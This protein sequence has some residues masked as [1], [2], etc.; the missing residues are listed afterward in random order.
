MP[1]RKLKLDALLE[2]TTAISDNV[3]EDDLYRI[4][5]F[6][7]VSNP[8]LHKI[9][10]FVEDGEEWICKFSN[11]K[12]LKKDAHYFSFEI[13]I[14]LENSEKPVKD[15]FKFLNSDVDLTTTLPIFHRDKLLA[16]I[17][18]S[19]KEEKEI[20]TDD[21]YPI[22]SFI[23]TL[24]RIV[25]TAIENKRMGR[26]RLKQEALNKELDIAKEVQE[27]LFPKK[28]TENNLYH[29]EAS[30]L[31][32]TIVG[33]D[34]YDYI[35]LSDDEFLVCIADV[36]GKGVPASILM[37]NFQAGL[38]VL[39]NH[40]LK[41]SEILSDLNKMVYSNANAERF[42]TAFVAICNT[43]TKKIR[44]INAG[45]TPPFLTNG[46]ITE[47]LSHGTT[48]IGAVD[49][50]PYINVTEVSYTKDSLLFMYTDG[51]VETTNS[52]DEEF[53]EERIKKILPTYKNM[54]L[55]GFHK[56]VL[57]ELKAFSENDQY[58]D[59]LTILSCKFH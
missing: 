22:K 15:V 52:S 55:K 48:L 56:F 23:R 39:S 8:Q 51:L 12:F 29:V 16:L 34:Y 54:P 45:H 50:L 6:T 2:I 53:G 40:T 27:M 7:M 37:S 33:G 36:S 13:N 9:A 3:S 30:Y 14:P 21:D 35:K 1:L 19:E 20:T 43:A 28:L 57:K 58:G 5:Y 26:L 31:P 11:S 49:E 59:D 10:L 17:L 24:G 46:K 18:I 32:H 4:F 41:L 44:Y 47:S 42:I 25:M 38:R